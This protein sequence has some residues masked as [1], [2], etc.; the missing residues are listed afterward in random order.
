MSKPIWKWNDAEETRKLSTARVMRPHIKFTQIQIFFIVM[1][2]K[3]HNIS[4]VK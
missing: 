3:A 2:T 4:N 1:F